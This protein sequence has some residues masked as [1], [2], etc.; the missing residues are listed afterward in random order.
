[1]TEAAYGKGKHDI[2]ELVERWK[3]LRD[4]VATVLAAIFDGGILAGEVG[5]GSH[6][7]EKS[8]A[9]DAIHQTNA[10]EARISQAS[11]IGARAAAT[12]E[13]QGIN[14]KHGEKANKCCVETHYK[15]D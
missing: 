7:R 15:S 4:N 9:A 13:V 6:A 3:K 1:M 11:I 8:A 10:A 12:D 5:A 2:D 14:G